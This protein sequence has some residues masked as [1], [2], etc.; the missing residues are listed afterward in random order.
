MRRPLTVGNAPKD[1]LNT[2]NHRQTMVRSHAISCAVIL[3]LVY[4]FSELV[5]KFLP[6][7]FVFLVGQHSAVFQVFE[8]FQPLCG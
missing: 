6:F 1:T 4:L 5:N 8:F 2:H 3:W 7:G